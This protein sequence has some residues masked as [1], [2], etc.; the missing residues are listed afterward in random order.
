MTIDKELFNLGVPDMTI[1]AVNWMNENLTED[2]LV[3]E[4]GSGASTFWFAKRAKHVYS[5]EYYSSFFYYIKEYKLDTDCENITL[6]L[7]APDSKIVEGYIAKY[8]QFADSSFYNFCH[9]IEDYPSRIFDWVIIDGRVRKKCLELAI[10]NTKRGGIIIL[11]DTDLVEYSS[12][13]NPYLSDIE[14]IIDFK[15]Q[16]AT[17]GRMSQTTVIKL[18]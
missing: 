16:K 3:F 12:A 7:R 4:W 6:S 18:A 2:D 14:D 8:S 9:A 11:D 10:K 5:V 1:T 15:G 13:I 17:T